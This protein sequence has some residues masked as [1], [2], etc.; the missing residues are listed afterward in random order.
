MLLS[1]LSVKLVLVYSH[2]VLT[3]SPVLTK[4]CLIWNAYTRNRKLEVGRAQMA[5]ALLR[6]CL[7]PQCRHNQPRPLPGF[8]PPL[9]VPMHHPPDRY[10]PGHTPQRSTAR[11]DL[12]R[13]RA[14]CYGASASPAAVMRRNASW[15]TAR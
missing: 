8:L 12:A 10:R 11:L 4:R 13:V 7:C 14:R 5:K 15:R 1:R 2:A 6:C 9:H 3:H